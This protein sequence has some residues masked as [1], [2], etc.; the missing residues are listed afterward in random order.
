MNFYN[1]SCKLTNRWFKSI[2]ILNSSLLLLLMVLGILFVSTASPNVAK[3]KKFSRVLFHKK[4]LY[5]CSFIDFFYDIFFLF[6][7]KG[8]Y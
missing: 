3:S 5:I 6:F 8:Y 2:D 1:S 4:T 7:R